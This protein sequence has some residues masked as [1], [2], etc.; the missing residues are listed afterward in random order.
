MQLPARKRRMPPTYLTFDAVVIADKGSPV[1]QFFAA[2][3][4]KGAAVSASERPCTRAWT[5]G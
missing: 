2:A 1:T 5:M 3:A 4:G